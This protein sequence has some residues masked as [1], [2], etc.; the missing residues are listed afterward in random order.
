MNLLGKLFPNRR[1]QGRIGLDPHTRIHLI[2]N[3][4][5]PRYNHEIRFLVSS[6]NMATQLGPEF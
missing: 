5:T 6:D 2:Q 1:L 4:E 3:E